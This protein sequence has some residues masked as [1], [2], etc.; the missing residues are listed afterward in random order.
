MGEKHDAPGVGTEERLRLNILELLA[1]RRMK[2][3][4]FAERL[5][6][7]QS[8]VSKRLAGK[9]SGKGSRFQLSDLD[10]LG[11]V[12]GLSP[13]ELL[14]PRY[15]KWE[16]RSGTDRRQHG[17]RRRA[18]Q[19]GQVHPPPS[20]PDE[21]RFQAGGTAPPGQQRDQYESEAQDSRRRLPRTAPHRATA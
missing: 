15:G 14:E 7:S 18:V 9:A 11:A 10:T 3:T 4:E 5:G 19:K 20:Q 16:R 13:A 6:R 8:W 1:F 21:A 12:F 17:E 2:Q